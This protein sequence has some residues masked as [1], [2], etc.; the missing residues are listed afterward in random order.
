MIPAVAHI[1]V[2]ACKNR[3]SALLLGACH[4]KITKPYS[5]NGHSDMSW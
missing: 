2:V 3:E 1:F 4:F 5:K